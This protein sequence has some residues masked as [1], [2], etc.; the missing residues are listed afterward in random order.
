[1]ANS[2]QRFFARLAKARRELLFIESLEDLYMIIEIGYH[3]ERGAPIK[4]SDL[5]SLDIPSRSPSSVD[6]RLRNLSRRGLVLRRRSSVDKRFMELHLSPGA[7]KTMQK[8][9][10]ALHES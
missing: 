9:M 1:M 10:V 3:E 5:H 2:A 4:V 8:F 6:R 7:R